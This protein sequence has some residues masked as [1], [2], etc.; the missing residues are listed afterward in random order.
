MLKSCTTG[1]TDESEVESV[2]RN[3]RKRAGGA[4]AAV[5]VRG[6]VCSVDQ[7]DQVS[8]GSATLPPRT[9]TLIFVPAG[10]SARHEIAPQWLTSLASIASPRTMPE[11]AYW[12]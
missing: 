9:A 12:S 8:S 2:T 4:A 11:L 10:M 7:S 3:C 1:E 6:S 5:A